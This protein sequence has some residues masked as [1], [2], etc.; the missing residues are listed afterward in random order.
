M[1]RL[2]D[3]FLF[4]SG[5]LIIFL[6]H[7]LSDGAVGDIVFLFALQIEIIGLIIV[8]FR[9]NVL[10]TGDIFHVLRKGDAF[11]K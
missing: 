6:I 3:E 11:E 5:F 8:V 10:R 1:N 9:L 4:L 7:N 2:N